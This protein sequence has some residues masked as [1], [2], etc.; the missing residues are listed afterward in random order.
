MNSPPQRAKRRGD[1]DIHASGK[2]RRGT[3]GFRGDV[4]A[5]DEDEEDEL[6]NNVASKHW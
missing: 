4:G 2:R 3:A 5:E 1:G 6:A